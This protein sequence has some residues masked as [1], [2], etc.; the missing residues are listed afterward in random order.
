M[1]SRAVKKL[2][3]DKL[4]IEPVSFSESEVESDTEHG[5]KPNPFALLGGGA[6]DDSESDEEPE[7]H[8]EPKSEEPDKS[9]S[10]ASQKPSSKSKNKK[11]KKKA[12][13]VKDQSSQGK[14]DD[15]VGSNVDEDMELLNQL[16]SSSIS[17]EAGTKID[18]R[19]L[20]YEREL[21]QLFGKDA[22]ADAESVATSSLFPPI[23][24][25]MA[26]WG[27]RDG[28]TIPGTNRRLILAK[29]KST[30][31]P[32]LRREIMMETVKPNVFKFTHSESYQQCERTYLAL[33]TVGDPQAIINSV[34]PHSYYHVQTLLMLAEDFVRAGQHSEAADLVER[35]LVTFDRAIK[36]SFD[37][38]KS[39]LPF[40]YY[41]NRQFY[42]TLF[43]HVKVLMRR[44]TWRTALEVVKLMWSLDEK[45]PYGAGRLVDFFALNSAEYDYLLSLPTEDYPNIAYSQALA[46]YLKKEQDS[47]VVQ[48]LEKAVKQCPAIAHELLSLELPEVG[49]R[50]TVLAKM[51]GVQMQAL[52]QPQSTILNML[53][54]VLAKVG[55]IHSE[56]RKVNKDLARFVLLSELKEALS[57]LPEEYLS[58]LWSDDLL[59]PDDD[60]NP[61]N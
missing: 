61:Y 26:S 11:K 7:P 15:K 49:P 29:I 24:H 52:W 4:D 17:A 8:P 28:R 34:F 60:I 46:G 58:N 19:Y 45:D 56:P 35:C 9:P 18:T 41:E 30:F 54:Q 16:A 39:R 2:Y 13:K 25:K 14:A 31:P 38:G 33:R 43:R 59:P 53:H 21:G 1:S 37:L 20:D 55:D 10:P 3:G 51:Y 5:A 6:D 42:L 36:P 22:M 32:M 27:G 23:K 40:K 12:K 48:R 50:D 44:G 47:E 57:I